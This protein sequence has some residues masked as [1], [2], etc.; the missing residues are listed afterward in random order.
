M[1]WDNDTG[2]EPAGALRDQPPDYLAPIDPAAPVSGHHPPPGEAAHAMAEE[3]EH[4]WGAASGRLLPLLRPPGTGG[5][6]LAALDREQLAGEG[7]RTHAMPVIDP[8][9]AGL[10]VAYAIGA[11]G[12]DV[13]VNADHLLAWAVEPEQLRAAALANLGRWSAGASWTDEIDG[14][15]RIISSDTGDGSDAARILLPEVRRYLAEQ[16]G[17]TATRVLVGL[18]E[19]HLLVASA[20]HADDPEF[21]VLFRDFV[22]AH[23]DGADEPIDRRVFELVNG[24]LTSFMA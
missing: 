14:R 9:P 11:G 16:L 1:T 10:I 13:L 23:A 7:L 21:A 6:E 24:E 12:F 22:G 19:R 20:F 4:D 2:D 18:P 8:G 5:T 17:D 3:P 15:R